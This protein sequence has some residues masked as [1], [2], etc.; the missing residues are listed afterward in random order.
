MMTCPQCGHSDIFSVIEV[1]EQRSTIH[2]KDQDNYD[3]IEVEVTL[4]HAWD[5]VTCSACGHTFDEDEGRDGW[6]AAHGA[7]QEEH[8]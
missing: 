4:T 5:T 1:I 7:L 2:C 8:P 6:A 3:F